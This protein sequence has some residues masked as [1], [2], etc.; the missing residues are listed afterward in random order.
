MRNRNNPAG[1]VRFED[2]P[3]DAYLRAN[4]LLIGSSSDGRTAL[5][6]FSRATLWRMVKAGKFPAPLKISAGVTVWSVRSIRE[7][8]EQQKTSAVLH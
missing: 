1:A 8:L 5:L 7:W 2:L 4:Q 3:D 6:P